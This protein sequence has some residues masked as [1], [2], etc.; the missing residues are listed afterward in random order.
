MDR[1]DEEVLFL[2]HI[3]MTCDNSEWSIV[4]TI[5]F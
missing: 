3:R 5:A 2:V 4:D 1:K